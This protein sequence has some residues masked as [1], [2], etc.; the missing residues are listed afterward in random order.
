MKIETDVDWKLFDKIIEGLKLEELTI[1]QVCQRVYESTYMYHSFK[2]HEAVAERDHVTERMVAK[3][4]RIEDLE[5][6]N[7]DLRAQLPEGS[8][9]VPELGT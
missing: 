6:E 7:A 9:E 3:V 2:V 1:F 5:K 8:E 4:Q